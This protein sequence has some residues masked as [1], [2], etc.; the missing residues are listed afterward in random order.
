ME[1]CGAVVS[2][3]Y[4]SLG[5]PACWKAALTLLCNAV[6]TWHAVFCLG[7]GGP[8][9]ARPARFPEDWQFA[10]AITYCRCYLG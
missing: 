9:Q 6:L 4:C 7:E 3:L 10:H 2:S 8:L 5:H 1:F